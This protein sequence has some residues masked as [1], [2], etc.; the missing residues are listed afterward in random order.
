M[1]TTQY[2]M[3]RLISD[4]SSQ[5]LYGGRLRPHESVAEHTL[6]DL[7]A[8]RK[9]QGGEGGGENGENGND[10]DYGDDDDV[11]A[12]LLLLDTSGCG[13][14]EVKGGSGGS[15]SSSSSRSR[16]L[17]SSSDSTSN[18]REAAGAMAHVQRLLRAGAKGIDVGV[19]APY[20]AQ[21]ALLREL[22][23]ELAQK[24]KPADPDSAEISSVE[25][26][27]VDG[28]QGREK[29]AIVVSATRSNEA[30]DVGFLADARRMNVAVTRAR[31]H[32]CLVCDA[33]CVGKK[34]AFLKRLVEYFSDN[35]VHESAQ[36][37]LD[38]CE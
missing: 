2:R 10:G 22:R 38:E 9:E 20:S 11:L 21:V 30:G 29:E 13:C 17:A 16:D 23:A 7:I 28:F 26:S 27:T 4:W 12:P 32:V 1:L 8:E 33:D 31:R 37:L 15:S 24:A 5:E 18:P 19:V 35:G 34:D 14:D 6:G 3:H 36:S 25:I